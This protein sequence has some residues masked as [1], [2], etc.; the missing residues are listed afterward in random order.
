MYVIYISALFM[1]IVLVCLTVHENP[2]Q[3]PILN[4][5]GTNKMTF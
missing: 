3:N 1:F 2:E 5:S 4:K